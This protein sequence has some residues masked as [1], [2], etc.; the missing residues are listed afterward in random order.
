MNFTYHSFPKGIRVQKVVRV[1][2][3]DLKR[4]CKLFIVYMFISVYVLQSHDIHNFFNHVLE[5]VVCY[6]HILSVSY[7]ECLRIFESGKYGVNVMG[8]KRNFLLCSLCY[9]SNIPAR[10]KVPGNV[11]ACFHLTETDTVREN[12]AQGKPAS[13]CSTYSIDGKGNAT[14]D[15]AVDGFWEANMTLYSDSFMCTHTS[16]Q[17][18]SC[19]GESWWMVDLEQIYPVSEVVI[20]NRG[21]CCWDRLHNISVTV[22]ETYQDMCM[23]GEF[24]GP[25]RAGEIVNITCVTPLIGQYVRISKPTPYSLTLCE[26]AVYR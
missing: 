10:K 20:L 11:L 12:L 5:G 16:I 3:F 17:H 15:L 13:Q 25:G 9:T 8:Y 1:I 14:S 19:L 4:I 2:M 18:Q 24:E 22:G 7:S 6:K 23:C 26:V 21:D